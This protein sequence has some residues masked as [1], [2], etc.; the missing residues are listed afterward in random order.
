MRI[1]IFQLRLAAGL[2]LLASLHSLNANAETETV[3]G[4]TVRIGLVSAEHAGK[5]PGE[6]KTHLKIP[7]SKS[8]QH[9]VVSLSYAANGERIEDAKVSV[10]VKNPLG[11]V[12]KKSLLHAAPAGPSDYSEF[13]K[14]DMSGEYVITVFVLRKD[15]SEP[16]EAVFT[17]SLP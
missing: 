3:D 13:F 8:M 5:S 16:L 2:L 7:K 4:L 12:Q 9:L 11:Q 1:N 17:E 10:V 15:Q 14:F 6:L